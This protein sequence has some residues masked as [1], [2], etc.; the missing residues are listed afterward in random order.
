MLTLPHALAPLAQYHQFLVC[1]FVPDPE[2]PGKTQKY[3]LNAYTGERHDAHEPGI[4]LDMQRACD[5]ADSWNRAG[6]TRQRWYGVGFTFTP[7]DPFYF[8]DVDGCVDA[9]GQW[10]PIVDELF[11]ALPGACIEISQSG[12]GLHF[13]GVGRTRIASD[14]RRKKDHTSHL[15][16]LYTQGRFV[17]LTGNV[18][19]GDASLD[20][21]A[22]L[23][24]L[25][26]RH[27]LRTSAADAA[28]GWT[29]APH[30]DWRGPIDDNALIERALRSRSALAGFTAKAS[31][32]DLWERNVDVLARVYPPDINNPS[33]PYDESTVDMAL[34]QH[35]AFWT[36]SDC[37]RMERL[38]LRSAL[39]RG[40]WEDRPEYVRTT[41]MSAT[42][43]QTEFLSDKTPEPLA[44]SAPLPPSA[45]N[46][47][48]PNAPDSM[49][50]FKMVDGETYLDP[51]Q[52]VDLFVGCVY[53]C[54][55]HRVLVPGGSLL[56]PEQFKAM[57]GGYQLKM[58][59]SNTKTTRDA[60]EAFMQN[61]SFRAPRADTTCFRPDLA[62]GMLAN[63]GGQIKVNTFVPP[64]VRRVVGDVELFYKHLELLLPNHADRLNILYYM[65][66]VVQ[67]QGKKF[68]WAPV[69]QGVEGNGK[70]LLSQCVEYAVGQRYTFWPRADQLGEKFNSWLFNNIFIGVEDAFVP[71][72][73][74][75]VIEILKPMITGENLTKR[76][77]QTDGVRAET[78]ANFMLNMNGKAGLKK[79][80]NDRRL[81]ICY[82]QQ[83]EHEDLVKFG[84]T[85]AYFQRLFGWL[86]KDGFAIVAELLHTVPLP[87]E[88]VNSLMSRAPISSSHDE[89]IAQG[90]GYIEQEVS[91]AVEME[92]VGFRGGWISSIW[93]DRL[94]E[95]IGGGRSR[96]SFTKR[97]ELL[98]ALGYDWHPNLVRGR[99]NNDLM[100]D[101]GKPR[102]YIR[103]NHPDMGLTGAAAIARAYTAAQTVAQEVLP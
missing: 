48:A 85:G 4:W 76:A 8:I 99:V 37:E 57:Y 73:Q 43:M 98:V 40:K 19:A 92:A 66:A 22:G 103:K 49:P 11:A 21:S 31:F 36:G 56:K 13:I 65:A 38:M 26:D 69:L 78:C 59:R 102:L 23:D 63:Y 90:M 54:D 30:A 25:V 68:K 70:T 75:E 72:H 89:V 79:S 60:W 77:M 95:R 42:S 7:A 82:T 2:R 34:A 5:I 86:N 46:L 10:T 64:I 51:D 55:T 71:E 53:V 88:F 17:A 47:D 100:P 9:T 67:L 16:D 12:R 32:A 101:G 29:S 18:I 24:V 58:D 41:I 50:E 27:L 94:L 6:A 80:R 1:E 96:V 39:V 91:D 15:F 14:D 87:E 3:P 28:E 62:P 93:F 35:L 33:S 74:A 83:Q 84:M 44:T 61:T 52:Q 97:R 20:Q 45:R 81:F